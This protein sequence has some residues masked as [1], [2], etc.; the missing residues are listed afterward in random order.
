M[1][2]VTLALVSCA[3]NK[4]TVT[5]NTTPPGATL[6]LDGAPIGT[7][8][9]EQTLSFGDVPQYAIG[10][11]KDGYVDT[12]LVVAYE[13]TSQLVYDVILKEQTKVVTVSSDPPGATV[14]FDVVAD[15]ITPVEKELSFATVNEHLVRV[16]LEGYEDSPARAVHYLPRDSTDCF[17]RLEKKEVVALELMTVEPQP[18]GEGVKLAV[19]RQPTLAYF[20]VIERSP[21]V[22]SVTRVTDNEDSSVQIGP[23]ALSP[24]DDYIVYSSAFR[25]A[26]GATY[27]NLWK[28]NVGSIA[29]VR[30][31]YGKCLDGFPMFTPDGL[32]LVFSSNRVGGNPTLWKIRAEGAGGII[33]LTNSQAEDYGPS[34]AS[35]GELIAYAS[36][37]PGAEE[38]QIWT[39]NANGNLPTQLREGASPN[40]SPD[41]SR[42]LFV[43]RAAASGKRQVWMMNVDGSSETQLTDNT[44]YDVADPKWSPDGAWIVYA[45]DEGL[46]SSQNHNYDIWLMAADGSRKTQLTTNGSRDDAPCWNHQGDKI[47][48]RSNRGGV[49]NIWRFQPS[50]M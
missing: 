4:K 2:L 30:V 7:A 14:Y 40:L 5:I 50:L 9:L 46:D 20:E 8:P 39:I 15:G 22:T 21:N 29:R 27:S 26:G 37:P 10:A 11:S 41:G 13:P 31:T 45:S 43:R 18:T 3:A 47:Y 32:N 1:F 16:T 49:W 23:P 36:N 25:E 24:I 33:R 34:M 19:V 17:F 12:T 38:P 44:D 42:I 35:S 28:Q 48:F 6:S